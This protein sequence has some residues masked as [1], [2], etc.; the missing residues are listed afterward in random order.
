MELKEMET[1]KV[2]EYAEKLGKKVYVMKTSESERV[3]KVVQWFAWPN[4]SGTF[5]EEP[6]EER[7]MIGFETFKNLLK[8]KR[9]VSV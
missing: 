9:I 1:G 5:E 8:S 4:D 6:I 3:N 2:Y 7:T